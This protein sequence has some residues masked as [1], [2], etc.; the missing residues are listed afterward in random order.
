MSVAINMT[1][2]VTTT[3]GQLYY[4]YWITS[5]QNLSTKFNMHSFNGLLHYIIC[6]VNYIIAWQICST[7]WEKIRKRVKIC[8]FFYDLRPHIGLTTWPTLSGA[9]AAST[10]QIRTTAISV[11]TLAG[12]EKSTKHE[13][14]SSDMMVTPRSTKFSQ[15]VQKLSSTGGEQRHGHDAMSLFPYK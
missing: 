11:L 6:N 13:V 3:N 14:A 12:N 4:T 1:S 9:N 8:L 10:S 15:L 2:L 7:I 5:M